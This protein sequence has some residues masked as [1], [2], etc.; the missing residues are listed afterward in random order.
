[1][2]SSPPRWVAPAS[3]RTNLLTLVAA[4]SCVA[5][6]V[7]GT[8]LPWETWRSGGEVVLGDFALLCLLGALAWR[9]ALPEGGGGG[10]AGLSTAA[11]VAVLALAAREWAWRQL[12]GAL[13][14]LHGIAVCLV[15]ALFLGPVVIDL[16]A[17]DEDRPGPYWSAETIVHVGLGAL[18]V[19]W[20]A[21]ALL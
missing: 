19:V 1:M 17:A 12:P 16:A 15:V 9:L 6:I 13:G 11:I 20:T 21:L 14:V 4:L 10:I 2:T 7:L 8:Y 5:G 3:R 18:V